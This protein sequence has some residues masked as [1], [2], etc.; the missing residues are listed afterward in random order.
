MAPDATINLVVARDNSDSTIFR[1][2]TYAVK[3]N[4]GD[5]ISLS[6]G[7][8]ENCVDS[9]LR[10]AEHRLFQEATS[11]G[12]TLLA[13]TGDFGSAQLACDNNAFEK[14][15]SFPAD[16]PLVTAVG[17]TT[18]N[19][20]AE[21]G[22]Y[23]HETVWNESNAF[24]RASGGGYSRIYRVPAFQRGLLSEVVGRGVPDIALN[25]SINGGVIV[26]ESPRATDQPTINIMGGTSAAAP[27][28][29]GL[30]ADG[31]QMAHHCLGLVNPA[32]YRLGTSST[33][34]LVMNAITSGNNILL[35]SGFNGYRAAPGRNAATGR[36][37][38]ASADRRP[39]QHAHGQGAYTYQLKM[40]N[41]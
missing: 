38:P 36:S 15:V 35:S 18:L 41:T 28:L 16:D 29:A 25:A 39:T 4:L 34:N 22:Q 23:I 13:S 3:H 26:L 40:V 10:L 33:Y 19:A 5:V 30:I 2:L 6:F 14:A 37:V 31:V 21:T 8:N 1:V 12:M 7:E 17:G 20:D 27:E 9:F 32:L 11:K 24:N